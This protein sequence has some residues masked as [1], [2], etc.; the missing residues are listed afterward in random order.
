M[1]DAA[2]RLWPGLS[3][4]AVDSALALMLARVPTLAALGLSA[5][6]IAILVGAAVLVSTT[7]AVAPS[8]LHCQ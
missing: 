7:T 1:N 5:L 3:I 6:T 8:A 2:R 4:V